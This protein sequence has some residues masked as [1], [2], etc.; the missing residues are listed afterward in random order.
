MNQK[1]RT[2]LEL[3][4]IEGICKMLFDKI[5]TDE[6]K[7]KIENVTKSTIKDVKST[8]YRLPR[9]QLIAIIVLSGVYIS[10][11]DIDEAYEQYRYGLKPG[12]TLFSINS[13]CKPLSQKK[14]I[15]VIVQQLD[16]IPDNEEDAIRKLQYKSCTKIDDN[17][18]EYSFS[19]LS[20]YSYLSEDE[21]PKFIYEYE[22]L[23]V[24]ANVVDGFIA[25][26]NAPKKIT[27]ILK[28]IFSSI[29]ETQ[30][31]NIKITKLLIDRIFGEN[32]RRKGSFVKLDASEKEAEKIT[33]ADS[34]FSEKPSVLESVES[35]DMTGTYLEEQLEN[36]QS[37][38]LGIN[39]NEGKIYLTKNVSASVFRN[40][41]VKRIKDIIDYLNDSNNSNDYDIFKAKN[42]TDSSRWDAYTPAQKNLIEQVCFSIY[43]HCRTGQSTVTVRNNCEV[44]REILSSLFYDRLLIN[45]PSCEDASFPKCT[46]GSYLLSVTKQGVLICTSCGD[47]QSTLL[48]DEGHTVYIPNV[49][50]I[51]HILPT[52]KFNKMIADELKV[53]FSIE[54]TG[55]F[56][57][58]GN[59]V[60]FRA[61]R[62]GGLLNIKTIHEFAD[63]LEIEISDN[64]KDLFSK[65]LQGLKEKC[66][67]STNKACANCQSSDKECI[68]KI[69]TTHETYRPSP[70]HGYEFGDVN[71]PVTISGTEL[72]LVGLA[73]SFCEDSLTPS[74]KT[75]REIIQQVLAY[76]H[77]KRI[78]VIA[79]ICPM[80]FHDQLTQELAYISKLSS[81][82]I[83]ILDDRFMVRQLKHYRE[84]KTDLSQNQ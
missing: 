27:T 44:Y 59:T 16:R 42:I 13:K 75:G 57:I 19:Y 29:Y 65:E 36:D 82:N 31:I 74:S 24:W 50:D 80:P 22:E 45:C 66:K 5:P 33:I 4:R 1:Q 11:A 62:T 84:M 63:T 78:G 34:R 9:Y 72:E 21:E 69:F 46:C 25:I 83:C 56:D 64:E 48:C 51:V 3:I 60:T 28:R 10:A 52:D 76:T 12:F 67:V 41:S 38:T 77:D 40:W 7:S 23:Y 18:V 61:E 17:V 14:I 55:Y 20:K 71:F 81:V 8:L 32:N 73:K 79:A 6:L 15:E 54:Y 26:K 49:Y 47:K 39:C 68:M 37:S 70:H 30:I 43:T 58:S 53:S 35:Y 2:K